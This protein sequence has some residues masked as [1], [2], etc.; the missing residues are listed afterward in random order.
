MGWS[1][2]SEGKQLTQL[3]Q[4]WNSNQLPQTIVHTDQRQPTFPFLHGMYY[5]Q[6]QENWEN[7]SEVEEGEVGVQKCDEI[8]SGYSLVYNPLLTE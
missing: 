3:T 6:L 7:F 8:L 4:N 1:T 2:P 5:H